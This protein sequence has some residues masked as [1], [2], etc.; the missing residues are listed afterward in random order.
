MDKFLRRPSSSSDASASECRKTKFRK[1]DQSY[2][3]FGFTELADKPQCVVCNEVLS[4]ESMKPS[5]MKRHL[6]TKHFALKDKP[7]EFFQRKL[8]SLRSQQVNITDLA[9]VNKNA[10]KAS[11]EVA[12]E[13]A[14]KGKPHTIAEELILPAAIDMVSNIISPQDAEKLKKIPLSNDTI[15]RRICDMAEDVQNQ[16]KKQ[17]KDSTFFAIQ[18]DES[19]DVANC[20]QFLCFIRYDYGDAI[21]ENIL[22]CK[23]LPNNTTGESLY[24]VFVQAT[25]PF[26]FD[27]KKCVSICSDGAMALTG[28]KSGLIARLKSLTPN[29]SW[30]H[31]FL[32]RQAL[33]AKK[34]P[35]ELRQV[36]N[37]AV[38]IVNYIKSRPL[39]SRMFNILCEE[40][41]A[42]HK[43][44]LFHTE[45]RWLSRGNVLSRLFGL[46]SEMLLFLVDSKSELST[47]FSDEKWLVKLA[48]LADIFSHLNILNLSLQGPDKNMIYAQ[49]RVNAFVK[50]LS[51][52]NARVKKEDFENFTLTQEFIG[53]L[54]TSYCTSPD[55]SSLSL[56]VSSH[57]EGLIEQLT[58]Y[59]PNKDSNGV[60]WV[61]NPFSDQVVTKA[62]LTAR[63]HDQ[64]IEISSDQSAKLTFNSACIDK[65]WI[66]IKNEYPELST[67]ALQTLMPFS[68]S[69]NC[70]Q[71]FS[72]MVNIKTKSRNRL[73]LENDIL[74]CITKLIPDIKKLVNSKQAHVSH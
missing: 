55:T 4:A 8:F 71:G 1:Y 49:D 14:K 54:S 53:F 44:L 70:E 36:L 40:V 10:L 28:K 52:W 27:W 2:I 66:G 26:E 60:L 24:K 3:Q 17:I 32:H 25:E 30:V 56:L 35:D 11:Y 12:L 69:Y 48:Y 64:L 21:H 65:F 16:L 5:K 46:K 62:E 43:H 45:V 9:N 18:L 7:V 41:G 72:K 38:K 47:F 74:L 34:M 68:T 20:A 23:P 42:L 15:S 63:Q 19:T 50:K 67:K 59:I 6:E 73:T 57:L 13:I 61:V 31:C 37:E 22:F 39:Q 33:A 51:V 29:A 58:D